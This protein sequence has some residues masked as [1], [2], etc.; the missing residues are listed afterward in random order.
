MNK[1]FENYNLKTH[2]TEWTQSFGQVE[3]SSRRQAG[4]TLIELLVVIAIIGILS[5]VVLVSLQQTR[6]R[7]KD[8]SAKISMAN[9]LTAAENYYT[10]NGDY[11]G[12]C[13]S[14]DLIKL[15]EGVAKQDQQRAMIITPQ[16]LA[17][18]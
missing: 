6:S 2:P 11:D 12:V 17:V 3:N 9:I 14:S 16:F 10:D 8:A 15:R 1:S 7:G 13:E 5:S 4:F 18:I